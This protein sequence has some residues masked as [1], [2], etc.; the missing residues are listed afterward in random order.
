MAPDPEKIYFKIGELSEA[1]KVEAHVLRFWEKEFSQIRPLRVGP[2][3]RLYRRKDLET[4]REIKR[5]LYDERFTIAGAKKCLERLGDGGGLFDGDKIGQRPEAP[6]GAEEAASL[7]R[8]LDETRREL[9]TIRQI[10]SAAPAAASP[11]TRT[12]NNEH[13]DAL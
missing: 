5:L 2:R 13:D 12:R 1:L 11:S 6:P 3:K 4:F 9:L 8:L 7:R 10:L